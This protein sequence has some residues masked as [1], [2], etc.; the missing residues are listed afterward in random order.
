M[1][2]TNEAAKSARR[3][4]EAHQHYFGTASYFLTVTPDSDN[5]FLV[6]VYSQI[7]V[8]D[9]RPIA[10]LSDEELTLRAKQR[11]QLRIKYPGICSY[12]FELVLEIV[13]EEVIGWNLTEGQPREDIV[14][15]FGVPQAFTAS[16]KEQGRKTLHAHIQIW[17]Q[18]FNNCRQMLLSP[19]QSIQR[20]AT[21]S[22][23][24][25]MDKVGSC[26]LFLMDQDLRVS[27]EV[28]SVLPHQCTIRAKDRCVAE[29]LDEQK[30]CNL[31][32]KQGSYE[33]GG[34]FAYCPHCTKTWTSP[35]LVESYLI[36]KAKVPGLTEYPEQTT[37][38]LKAMAVEYQKSGSD[39]SLA[40]CIVDAA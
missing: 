20:G 40:P 5:S 18:N 23:I 8:D 4:R 39:V 22:I 35:E 29:I 11:L 10:G 19:S 26:S 14:D 32:Y 6:Q 15:L 24:D 38:R 3:D 36:N 12:F 34:M 28:A 25:C 31:R 16:V 30:L 17:V 27:R 21:K 13:I 2:H 1:P 7:T 9:D 33:S 37:R